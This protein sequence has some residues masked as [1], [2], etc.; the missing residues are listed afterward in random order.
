[1]IAEDNGVLAT[2]EQEASP[3]DFAQGRLI[4]RNSQG[5]EYQFSAIGK[6]EVVV[7]YLGQGFNRCAI[8]TE[9]AVELFAQLLTRGYSRT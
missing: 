4:L 1:M 7:L 9:E 2:Q 5:S 8:P 6:K 3:I